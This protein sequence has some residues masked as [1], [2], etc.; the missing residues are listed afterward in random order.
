MT[1]RAVSETVAA[2]QHAPAPAVTVYCTDADFYAE[3]PDLRHMSARWWRHVVARAS[4]EVRGVA[5]GTRQA[6]RE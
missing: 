4:H 1:T 5:I 6:S 2:M 3:R